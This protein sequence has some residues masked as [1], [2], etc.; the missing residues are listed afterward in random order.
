MTSHRISSFFTILGVLGTMSCAKEPD[1]YGGSA[2]ATDSQPTTNAD[3]SADDGDSVDTGMTTTTASDSATPTTTASDSATSASTAGDDDSTTSTPSTTSSEPSDESAGVIMM[4]DIATFPVCDI[5]TQDCPEG[6]K[7]NLADGN[8]D[9]VPETSW[10]VPVDAMPKQVGDPC[11]SPGGY[12][13]GVDDCDKGL[14]CAPNMSDELGT[15][16]GVCYA[17]CTGTGPASA[18]CNEGF[19]CVDGS[20][21]LCF[22][23]CDPLTQDC[24]TGQGCYPAN[25]STGPYVCIVTSPGAHGEACAVGNACDPGLVCVSSD[26]VAGCPPGGLCCTSYCDLDDPG[27]SANCTGA[28]TGE[29]CT[30]FFADP[31]PGFENV[32]ICILPQ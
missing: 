29:E 26:T 32:G 22:A 3:E 13:S 27:A 31:E 2:T 25:R 23:L 18:T 24:S 12:L 4:P 6:D 8:G 10:C 17:L 11:T 14:M 20:F 15:G 5:W 16:E 1:P 30:A 9:R 21:P 19:L 7:C 28:A